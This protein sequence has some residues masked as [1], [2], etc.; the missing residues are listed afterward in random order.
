MPRHAAITQVVRVAEFAAAMESHRAAVAPTALT[1]QHLSRR[2]N[3]RQSRPR[4]LRLRA[5]RALHR[6]S[7]HPATWRLATRPPRPFAMTMASVKLA[8]AGALGGTCFSSPRA[9]TAPL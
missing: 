5:L 3:R 8:K 7:L 4:A 9:M 1:H 6:Q 2:R